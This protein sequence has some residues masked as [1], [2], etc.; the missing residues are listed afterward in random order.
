MLPSLRAFRGRGYS[1]GWL[2]PS[3]QQGCHRAITLLVLGYV[4]PR[5]GVET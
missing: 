1:K 4:G 5:D 2:G 3:W